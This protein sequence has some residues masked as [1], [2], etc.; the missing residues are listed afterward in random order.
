MRRPFLN[1]FV[2]G[3]R[4]ERVTTITSSSFD[5]LDLGSCSTHGRGQ[6]TAE[7]TYRILS[8]DN[9]S[10]SWKQSCRRYC[11]DTVLA[12]QIMRV[13]NVPSTFFF[14]LKELKTLVKFLSV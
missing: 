1:E 12:L 8:A 3:F 2:T 5:S 6:S 14:E 9:I 7:A 10:K 4:V 11:A 13:H